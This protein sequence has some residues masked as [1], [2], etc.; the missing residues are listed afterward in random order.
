MRCEAAISCK[1][2]RTMLA[3]RNR[4]SLVIKQTQSALLLDQQHVVSVRITQER[5][6]RESGFFFWHNHHA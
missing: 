2:P 1:T 3:E 6:F 4:N 5:A